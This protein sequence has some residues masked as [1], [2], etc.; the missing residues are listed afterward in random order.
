MQQHTTTSRCT[1][2]GIMTTAEVRRRMYR[3]KVEPGWGVDIQPPNSGRGGSFS[4]GDDDYPAGDTRYMY[5]QGRPSTQ[6]QEPKQLSRAHVDPEGLHVSSPAG[7]VVWPA[8]LVLRR[9]IDASRSRCE[10]H[11]QAPERRKSLVQALLLLRRARRRQRP[12]LVFF[13]W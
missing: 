9:D 10:A 1:L 6:Q 2:S 11:R 3:P 5:K 4:K 7:L 12:S 8:A 13:A